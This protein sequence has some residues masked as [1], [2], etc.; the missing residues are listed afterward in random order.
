M[1]KLVSRIAFFL[2][3]GIVPFSAVAQ[4]AKEESMS[5]EY[6]AIIVLVALIVFISLLVLLVLVQVLMG[7]NQ[8]FSEKTESSFNL[9]EYIWGLNP[10][11][12]EKEMLLEEDFDGIRELNNPTPGWFNVLFGGTIAFGIVYMAMYHVFQTAD[13][14]ETEYVKEVAIAEVKQ[15][16]YLKKMAGSIDENS[17]KLMADKKSLESGTKLYTQYCAAC[18]GTEGEGKVGPNLT[19]EYWLHGGSVADVFKTIKYGVPEKGM[20]SWQKQLNPLQIQQVASYILSLQGTKPANPKE[21]QGEKFDP[22]KG[23]EEDKIATAKL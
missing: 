7:L 10:M 1:K 12:K 6:I 21:P 22:K 17:V 23:S 5:P 8:L 9:W 20:I 2:F 16:E 15:Q 4:T 3:T 13:L 18:H 11:A 19:D 14:Q